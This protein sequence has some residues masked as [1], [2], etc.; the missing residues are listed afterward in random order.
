MLV[1][2]QIH[3]IEGAV[4]IVLLAGNHL[5]AVFALPAGIGD[6]AT[7][8]AAPFVGYMIARNPTRQR[9]V[10][11]WNAFGIADLLIA[12]TGFLT[13]PGAAHLLALDSPNELLTAYPLALIPIYAVPVSL[14]LHGLVCQRLARIAA[15][16]VVLSPAE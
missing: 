5:P 3:R 14:I 1:A 6:V 12:M 2:V 11:W 7:G 8:L 15:N 4:F 16:S 9:N 10:A 13:S